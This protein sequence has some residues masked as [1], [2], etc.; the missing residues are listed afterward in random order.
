MTPTELGKNTVLLRSYMASVRI[1]KSYL[2]SWAGSLVFEE[3]WLIC[4]MGTHCRAGRGYFQPLQREFL[5][6]GG[7]KST[8][9][10]ES[11]PGG[12]NGKEPARNAWE[13]GSIPGLG[14]SPAEENGKLLQYSC[15]ENTMDRGAWQA[16][17]HG[18]QIVGHNWACRYTHTHTA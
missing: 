10:R 6:G 7:K 17:F 3:F 18:S 5:K 12:S 2:F 16:T 4:H 15:L 14:K 8:R 11:F 13:P 1:L 9:S